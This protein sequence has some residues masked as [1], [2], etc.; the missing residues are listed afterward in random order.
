MP[1]PA[2]TTNGGCERRGARRSRAGSG[3]VKVEPTPGSLCDGQRAA[4][5][6]GQPARQRQAEAGAAHLPL[7]PMLELRELLEDPRLIL[8]RDA[9]AGV[10]DAERHHRGPRRR[11]GADTRTSPRSVNF[12]RVRDQ[13]AQN[14]RHLALRRCSSGGTPSA[15]SKTSAT[16]WLSSSGRSMP[17]S[18][19]NSFSTSKSAGPHDGL[20]G[21]DLGE[22]EQVV[23]Q[24]GQL[25]G[26][27]ADVAEL[28]FRRRGRSLLAFLDQQIAQPD[29]RV[30]RR[31]ELVGHVREEARLQL[32]GAAQVIGS[33][34]ELGVERDD[35]A[36]G[37][38]ELAIE[39]HELL[40]L[41]LQLVE[42]AQQLLVLLLDL[43]DQVAARPRRDGGR[44]LVGAH[45]R[46]RARCRG[47]RNLREHDRRALRAWC[48]SK[49][50]ISRRAPTMP[51]PMPVADWYVPPE[52]LVQVRDAGPAILDHARAAAAGGRR[53]RR[54]TGRRRR[55][56][57]RN[58]F[59]TISD[60]AVAIRVC[61]GRRTRAG[62]RSAPHIAV[63][64]TTS[65]SRCE[66]E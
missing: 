38:F 8:R 46:S 48:R 20:A 58:A 30:H 9:D 62:L 54:R 50:S 43:F 24:L 15:S 26:G 59:R 14:L 51:M 12:K 29:D 17:R 57:Y 65:W 19:P 53:D 36:V 55:A 41:A 37:V 52:H 33:L 64:V 34:V 35:A 44:D 27:L 31:A 10:G 47:G 13:V 61:S 66:S 45:G 21:F 56:A 1:G 60:T 23:D 18:A 22:V 40:L 6:L 42:R 2:S 3:T 63:A 49:S 16:D 4:E 25:F 5:Q 11:R 28:R 32:V 7:Q 39:A